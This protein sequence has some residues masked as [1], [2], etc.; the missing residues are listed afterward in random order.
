M[1]YKKNRG[2]FSLFEKSYPEKQKK[3]PIS[4]YPGLRCE[5]VCLST[6]FDLRLKTKTK[7]ILGQFQ[8]QCKYM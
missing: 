8:F 6:K 7:K 3:N 2:V 4:V 5:N 1:P